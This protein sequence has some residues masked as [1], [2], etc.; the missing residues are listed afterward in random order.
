MRIEAAPG[1]G[2]VQRCI[3]AAAQLCVRFLNG[4]EEIN[5]I[6][7]SAWTERDSRVGIEDRHTPELRAAL[8]PA[9]YRGISA[10]IKRGPYI[11][12][13]VRASI[14]LDAVP[15]GANA[16]PPARQSYRNLTNR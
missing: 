14:C 11:S 9:D 3:G 12:T 6:T 4:Y 1:R 10:R 8:T 5:H 16:T 2:I 13:Y 15:A 7:N